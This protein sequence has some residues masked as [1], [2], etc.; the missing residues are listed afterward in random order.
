MPDMATSQRI[1]TGQVSERRVLHFN[2][3]DEVLTDVD[4]L[5]AADREGRLRQLGNW[6]LGPKPRPPRKLDQLQL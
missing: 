1:N 3:L 2:T 6:T 4:Q 5:A